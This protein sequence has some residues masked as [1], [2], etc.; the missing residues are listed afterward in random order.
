MPKFVSISISSILGVLFILSGTLKMMPL[1]YLENELLYRNL[2]T[3]ITVLFESRFIIATEF[4]LGAFLIS[5]IA[6][7]PTAWWA[8]FMLVVYTIY[9]SIVLLLEGNEGNCGCFGPMLVLTPL[10]GILKNI[11]M[12]ALSYLLLK[13]TPLQFVKYAKPIGIALVVIGLVLPYVLYPVDLPKPIVDLR[14]ENIR[15]EIDLLYAP[16]FASAPSTDLLKGKHLICFASLKC[17][18]CKMVT[19][20]LELLKKNNPEWPIYLIVNGNQESELP[21]FAEETKLQTLPYSFFNKGAVLQQIAGT[22]YPQMWIVE[23]G[24]LVANLDYYN[25]NQEELSLQFNK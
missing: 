3:E 24:I 5:R 12:I 11:G 20:K 4:I 8:L 17:S 14:S 23:D 18:R 7:K 25:L 9:L 13:K 22:S 2:G 10:E 21:K 19:A 1:E 15:P 16:E 6:L